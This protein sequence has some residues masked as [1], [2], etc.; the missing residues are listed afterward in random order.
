[1]LAA[2]SCPFDPIIIID[3]PCLPSL[4]PL[5]TTPR[6]AEQALGWLVSASARRRPAAPKAPPQQL[7]GYARS[8]SEAWSVDGHWVG[9]DPTPKT[10]QQ[11]PASV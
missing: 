5:T 3:L 7:V 1:M 8:E 11:Q 10:E 9:L 4:N 2:S 6:L